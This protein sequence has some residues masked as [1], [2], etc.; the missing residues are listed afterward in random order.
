MPE[1]RPAK[2]ISVTRCDC[3]SIWIRLHDQN[4]EIFA[5]ACMPLETALSI[6]EELT[7]AIEAALAGDAAPSANDDCAGACMTAC[8]AKQISDQMVCEP[9]ALR[10]DV[11]D[12]D[13]PPRRRT[14]EERKPFWGKCRICGHCWPAAYLPMEMAL[15]A[16]VLKRATCPKCGDARPGIA[17]QDD[18]LLQEGAVA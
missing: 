8:N 5:H 9:C 15:C 10:W 18:G 16:K 2:T 1:S 11:N 13:P 17:R 7:A 6:S 14:D 3:P 12:S 4:G